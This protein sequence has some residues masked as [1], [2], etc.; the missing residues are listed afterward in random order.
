MNPRL[1]QAYV[2]VNWSAASKA[3]TGPDSIWVGVMKRNVRFQMAFEAHNPATRAEAEK[4]IDAQLAEL[5]RKS[6]RTLVGVDFPLGFPRGTAAALKLNGEPW[7]A[8]LDFVA[9]EVKDKPD[10][11]NNRFQVGAKMNR[12]MTGEAFPFWGAPARDTQTMLSAKRVRDHAEG[13]LPE[14][15]YCEEAGKSAASMWKLYYQGSVGGQALTGMP[16]VKRLHEKRAAKLWPFETGWRALSAA[17]LEGV[18]AVFAEVSTAA[19]APKLKDEAQLRAVCEFFNA[20]DEK[21]QLGAAFGPAKD[22][23]RREVVEREEGWMLGA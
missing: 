22:D 10:N 7:R 17:D 18:E 21:G 16:I 23:P 4:L 19:L 20:R 15:R 3:T 6:E 8:L 1:F 13:D 5:S 2:M 14:F 12:L 11:T 9:K